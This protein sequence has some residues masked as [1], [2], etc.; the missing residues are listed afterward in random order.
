[1][2]SRARLNKGVCDTPIGLF[3]EMPAEMNGIAFI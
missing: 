3:G 1:M 2:G